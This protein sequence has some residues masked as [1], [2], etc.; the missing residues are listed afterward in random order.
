MKHTLQLTTPFGRTLILVLPLLCILIL[1]GE[2]IIRHPLIYSKLKTPSLN[3]RHYHIERQWYRLQE[4]T[5]TGIE[6]DCIALGNSMTV[7]SFDPILFS[8]NFQSE[9]GIEL[10]CFNFGVD[11]LTPV[12]AAYLA[13]I[14]TK[15]YQPELLIFGTD[16][17]DFAITRDSEETSVI[18]DLA[19]VPC[20]LRHFS[21]EGWLVDHSHLYQYRRTRV[22]LLHL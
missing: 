10:S 1:A 17:R 3:S 19:W 15:T 14:L 7:S 16:A 12:S 20:R 8:Q 21:L 4:L 13:Q 18:A 9:T 5:R 6:I 11:A 2:V 22:D